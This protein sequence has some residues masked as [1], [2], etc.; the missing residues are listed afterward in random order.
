MTTPRPWRGSPQCALANITSLD[1]EVKPIGYGNA[2]FRVS[3]IAVCNS[4]HA[5][6]LD[7]NKKRLESVIHIVKINGMQLRSI[8]ESLRKTKNDWIDWLND[9]ARLYK[10]NGM[11]EYEISETKQHKQDKQTRILAKLKH[12]RKLN[13]FELRFVKTQSKYKNQFY[14]KVKRLHPK[15]FESTQNVQPAPTGN[16]ALI[17]T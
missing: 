1:I 3:P 12:K 2:T 5:Y 14:R 9:F 4:K 7:S 13:A 11:R 17:N 6:F 15:L 16:V 10:M 8:N